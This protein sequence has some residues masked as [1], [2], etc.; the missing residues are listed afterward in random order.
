LSE[1]LSTFNGEHWDQSSRF[2]SP[3]FM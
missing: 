3:I 1:Y 2:Y